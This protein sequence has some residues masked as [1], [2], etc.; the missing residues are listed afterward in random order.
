M[1]MIETILLAVLGWRIYRLLLGPLLYLYLLVPSGEFLVPNLQDLTARF[2]VVALGLFH[3]PTFSDGIMISI[4]EGDFIIA[5][6]C[7]GL[8]FL[9]ASIAFGAFFAVMVYRSWW[10]RL[11]FLALSMIV[12]IIANGIRAWG[13]LYIAHLTND[14]VAVEADHVVY[15]W[16]FFSAIILL[17]IVIG[18]RFSD[19]GPAL[20]AAKAPAAPAP[21]FGVRAP[22]IATALA[23]ALAALGPIYANYLEAER[24]RPD[25]S[26][27]TAPAPGASW[28][29]VD[30][31]GNSWQP[32]VIAPDREFRDAFADKGD[33]VQRYV[34]LYAAYGRHNNLVRSQNRVMDGDVWMR[35]TLGQTEAEIDGK[36]A[37]IDTAEIRAGGRSRLVW[38]FYVVDGTVTGSATEAKLR[39]ARAILAGRSEIS[40]FIAVGADI[41]LGIDAHPE[42]TLA[43][44]VAAMPP[45]DRY[46]AAARRQGPSGRRP[47]R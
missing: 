44:F 24:W 7:A 47:R 35:T 11:A 33:T 40:A 8:R 15:G 34:A 39:Q 10:R 31:S 45:L 13:I 6:A 20:S 42:R 32:L 43:D 25:L 12:P 17:L 3:V 29:E 46:L 9:I 28:H 5:E 14:V 22:V 37:A 18:T 2:V 19:G 1:T 21:G 38:Y 30:A 26:A 16:G 41:P 4:P 23:V 36:R 27:A